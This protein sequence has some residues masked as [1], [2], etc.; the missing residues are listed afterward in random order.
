MESFAPAGFPA[1]AGEGVVRFDRA[2]AARLIL[3][4]AFLVAAAAY[5]IVRYGGDAPMLVLAALVGG[6]MALNIGANDVANNVGPT[7][8]ARAMPITAAL[9]MAALGEV[10]G[11]LIAGGEVV[12]TIRSG[13]IEPSLIPSPE[14]YVWVMMAALLAA[15]IW[16]NL[17]TALGAP[18]STTHAIVGG[19]LGAGVAAAG[20]GVVDW[21]V[22][23]NI[24]LSWVI[25][26][27]FGA[28]MAAALLYGAKRGI[29]YQPDLIMAARRGVPL[30]AAA[31]AWV[32][33][34]YLLLE[35]L[36]KVVPVSPVA[37]AAGGLLAGA[38]VW[39]VMRVHV[40]RRAATL[41]N[42]KAGV[43]RLLGVPLIL[44]A[45][46]LSFAHGS[47][48]VAN[49]IGPLAGIVDA[50]SSGA[51][52]GEAAVPMWVMLLGAFGLAIGLLTFGPRVIR[53]VGAELTAL[54]ALRAYCIAMSAALTVIV[55]SHLGM[56]ISTTHVTV[57]AILGVGYL[58][59]VLKAR[60][61][62][63]IAAIRAS[64]AAD[65]HAGSEAFIARFHAVPFG[66]RKAMLARLQACNGAGG[67]A[68]PG[69]ARRRMPVCP[70][71]CE[72]VNRRLM[73]RIFAAW[74]ITVPATAL[75]ANLVF[76]T[77][78]GMLLP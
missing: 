60:H 74:V 36:A 27:L 67:S 52:H 62:A 39:A 10:A 12:G 48:D 25:S 42:S 40:R 4:I 21:G 8:G 1:C 11:A 45:A 9:V 63:V 5:P 23:G 54:D 31:M 49:A 19:V 76:Y 68:A 28:A 47:N 75:V 72:I 61:A 20:S 30:L 78:R 7:V 58:R 46:A 22:M 53:T 13:I 59:E 71:A 57:G 32:F 3:A 66:Q 33:T 18:V 43:N 24:A 69:T 37:A 17:A 64:H 6:Y 51:F 15:A 34:T 56:P 44:A 35:G 26:P 2:L 38:A 50:L 29:T 65:D 77:L 70:G 55:A 41:E 73:L 14:A 16:L